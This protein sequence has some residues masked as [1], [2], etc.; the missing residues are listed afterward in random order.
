MPIALLLDRPKLRLVT[1][2]WVYALLRDRMALPS[3]DTPPKVRVVMLAASVP[4]AKVL[5]NFAVSP[6]EPDKV[7]D[8]PPRLLPEEIEIAPLLMVVPPE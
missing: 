8:P 2:N 3:I 6:P 4:P 5:T 7:I 1:L